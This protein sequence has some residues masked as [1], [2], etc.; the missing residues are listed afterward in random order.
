MLDIESTEFAARITIR[1]MRLL[2]NLDCP[3]SV[4]E[5]ARILDL[6][7]DMLRCCL[8][9]LEN[10]GFVKVVDECF[11]LGDSPAILWDRYKADLESRIG[12]MEDKK[13]KAG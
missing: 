11:E 9:A 4:F 5:V 6:K 2:A 10:E 7:Y 13:I 8:A 3:L 12:M 1:I